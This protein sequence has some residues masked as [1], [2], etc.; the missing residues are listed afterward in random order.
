MQPGES[1]PVRI[2]QNKPVGVPDQKQSDVVSLVPKGVL[3]GRQE[4]SSPGFQ[5]G[6]CL[7]VPW[8]PAQSPGHPD[9]FLPRRRS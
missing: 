2:H 8:P 1:S 9:P 3:S 4:A 5:M 7:Q 6:V